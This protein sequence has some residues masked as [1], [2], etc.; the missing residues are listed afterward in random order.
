MQ[1]PET[2]EGQQ[3]AAVQL[4]RT[5][6]PLDSMKREN[7]AALV[8]KV[9]VRTCTAGRALFSQGDTDKRTLRL[10]SGSLEVNENDRNTGVL[11]GGTPEA[12]NA[13]DPHSP[14]RV[15]MRAVDDVSYLA[16]D[17]DLLDVMITWDQ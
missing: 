16:I 12:R 10:I 1:Q 13:L 8:R 9:S 6:A 5:F 11:R 7:L 15:T 2:S 14:R 17:S 3:A 4:L